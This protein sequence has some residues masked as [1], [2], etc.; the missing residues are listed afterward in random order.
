LVSGLPMV[1]QDGGP[2][3]IGNA[4]PSS[5]PGLWPRRLT[6]TTPTSSMINAGL[7]PMTR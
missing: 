7:M 2:M 5:A 4:M 6:T 3:S 1:A